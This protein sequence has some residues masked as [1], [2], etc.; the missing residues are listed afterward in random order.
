VDCQKLRA[1]Y[2]N[3]SEEYRLKDAYADLGNQQPW[4][5]DTRARTMPAIAAALRKLRSKQHIGIVVV[6][7][8]QLMTSTGRRREQKRYEELSEI[9]H[10][11]KHIAVK[12]DVAMVV[13]CQLN[14]QCEIDNRQPQL[15]DL[16]E[17]SAAEQD[18]DVV[19]FVHRPERY[20][21][22]HTRRAAWLCGVHHS[23][24][25]VRTNRDEKDDVSGRNPEV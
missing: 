13:A 16:A 2:L 10:E 5:D 6:D 17:T 12:M 4:I 20:A 1:G 24:A 19:M 9:L 18:A 14:R 11:L 3:A 15:S 22:N 7:H 23:E 21:K 8:L 25:E